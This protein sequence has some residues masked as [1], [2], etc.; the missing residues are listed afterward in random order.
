MDKPVSQRTPV[1]SRYAF[2]IDDVT[3]QTPAAAPAP[4]PRRE[5]TEEDRLALGLA[6]MPHFA[7]HAPDI[8]DDATVALRE[9]L[10]NGGAL[11]KVAPKK[12]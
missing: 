1:E 2:D 7:H 5:L 11:G 6:S 12:R 9:I 8:R 10:V 4:A 3:P